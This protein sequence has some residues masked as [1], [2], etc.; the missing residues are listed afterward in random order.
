MTETETPPDGDDEYVTLRMHLRR[1][2]TFHE[3]GTVDVVVHK[4]MVPLIDGAS[5]PYDNEVRSKLTDTL[6]GKHCIKWTQGKHPWSATEVGRIS[7]PVKADHV[8]HC[9][10]DETNG[11]WYFRAA[12]K[13]KANG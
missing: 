1:T 3:Y 11:K 4:T 10:Y 9:R 13:G 5:E 8:Y 12:K 6:E 7:N 2:K